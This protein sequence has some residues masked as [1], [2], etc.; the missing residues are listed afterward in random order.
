LRL[1]PRCTKR[2]NAH[3][4]LQP[5]RDGGVKAVECHMEGEGLACLCDGGSVSESDTV[6]QLSDDAMEYPTCQNLP[7]VD[8]RGAECI[9]EAGLARLRQPDPHQWYRSQEPGGS[10][11]T[12]PANRVHRITLTAGL[13]KPTRCPYFAQLAAMT[14]NIAGIVLAPNRQIVR[15]M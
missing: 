5:I 1:R 6:D 10:G 3:V 9:G 13:E 4:V 8:A 7:D 11:P 15:E 12:L 2:H 14:V